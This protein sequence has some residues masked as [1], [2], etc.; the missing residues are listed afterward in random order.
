MPEMSD[1][2]YL[3][4]PRVNVTAHLTC[5]DLINIIKKFEKYTKSNTQTRQTHRGF[6][7]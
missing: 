3:R 4:K 7:Y 5:N 1:L 2:C 6:Y